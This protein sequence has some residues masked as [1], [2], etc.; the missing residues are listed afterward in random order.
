VDAE[1]READLMA[2]LLVARDACRQGQG[3]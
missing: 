3:K 1:P 2:P